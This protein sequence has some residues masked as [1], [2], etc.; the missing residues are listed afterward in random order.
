MKLSNM[1]FLVL[2]FFLDKNMRTKLLQSIYSLE[3]LEDLLKIL[4]MNQN[5]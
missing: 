3:M 2:S 5:N 4:K 1:S